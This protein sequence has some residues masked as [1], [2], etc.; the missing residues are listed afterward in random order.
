M[1]NETK[2]LIDK[3]KSANTILLSAHKN[4]DGDALSSIL[5]MYQLIYLNYGKECVC[6][7]DGNVPE[8]L[9]YIP[10]RGRAHYYEQVDL[11]QPFDLAI[12]LD[13]GTTNNIGGTRPA[14]D[15]A[16]FLVEI[17]HHRN[18]NKI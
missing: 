10:L 5:A 13:Y 16:K 8:A 9:R 15:A 11:S 2:I 14:L 12:L 6:I 3:I 1:K 7:Y 18:D 4:P 17:Y